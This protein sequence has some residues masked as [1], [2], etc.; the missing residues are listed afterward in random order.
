MWVPPLIQQFTNNPGNMTLILRFFTGPQSAASATVANSFRAAMAVYGVLAIGPVEVMNLTIGRIFPN[1]VAVSITAAVLVAIG[2]AVVLVGWRRRHR[3][4]VMVGTLSL[5]GAAVTV[6]AAYSVAGPVW[7][8][9]LIWALA[10]PLLALIGVGVLV[11][12][13][14]DAPADRP[15]QA[16]AQASTA[17]PMRPV[18][19]RAAV[20]GVAVVVCVVLSIHAVVLPPLSAASDPV[21]GATVGLVTPKLTPGQPVEIDDALGAD[22]LGTERYI[23]VVNL[24]DA[25]GYDP[26]VVGFFTNLVGPGF[27]AT[28]KEPTLVTIGRWTASSPSLPGFVGRVGSYAITVTQR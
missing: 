22:L 6:V 3:F 5:V 12:A 13:P 10:A 17:T 15:T 19:L 11:L 14:A 27:L 23:G 18:I 26:K 1:P 16:P 4:A 9:L 20:C 25:R 24:L 2:V 28:G 7:G 8:Y 21:V